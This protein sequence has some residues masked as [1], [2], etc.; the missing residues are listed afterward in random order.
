[1]QS[2]VPPS[3]GPR[4]VRKLGDAA[5]HQLL[6]GQATLLSVRAV[7]KIAKLGLPFAFS[8]IWGPFWTGSVSETRLEGHRPED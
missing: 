5:G 1:M 4:P 3:K 7:E 2:Q 6:S 8:Q